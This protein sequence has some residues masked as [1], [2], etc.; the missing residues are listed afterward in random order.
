MYREAI[1]A[2][3]NL[4]WATLFLEAWKRYNAELSFRWGTTDIVSSKFEE[5]RANFYGQMG[6]NVVTG[7]PEPVYPK[8]KRVARFYGVTVPVV[9][10]WLIVAFYVMLGYFYLQAMADKQYAENKSWFNMGV[11]YLPTAIYAVIIGI[12]NTIYRSVAKKLND[13]GNLYDLLMLS[14]WEQSFSGPLVTFL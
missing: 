4:I 9:V 10:F 11:L 14:S 12:V 2:V 8:W 6:R 7:K 5:P 1:F 3:F 13:W